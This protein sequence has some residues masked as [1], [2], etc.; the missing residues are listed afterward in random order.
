MRRLS[1]ALALIASASTAPAMSATP[2]LLAARKTIDSVIDRSKPELLALY[3]DLHMHPELSL[4]ET[5]TAARL[6]QEMR[7]LGLTVTEKVGGT[8]LVA[9]LKNGDGP[10]VLIRTDLDALPMRELSDAPFASKEEVPYRGAKT[11]VAHSCGHDLHMTWWLGTAKALLAVKDQW[12][13]TVVFVGQPA[14]EGGGGAQK[15][16]DDGLFTR[17]PKPDYGFA[18]HVGND[19][20]GKVTVK[21]GAFTSNSD[22]VRITFKGKGGHGSMPSETIDPIVMGARFV[23]DVQTVVSRQKDPFAFGVVTVGAFQAGT[24]PNIIPDS[25]ALALTIRSFSPSVREQLVSG[26]IRTAQTVATMS[27]APE[28]TVEHVKGASSVIN[29]SALAASVATSLKAA[30]SDSIALLP[31]SAPGSSASEDYSSLVSASGM[32]SVYLGIGGYLPSVLDDYRT[33]GAA[34]PTNH[35]PHFLPDAEATIPVGVRSFA[36]AALSVLAV[37]N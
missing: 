16:V 18:A 14:E 21:Q 31:E 35:S 3:R 2:D 1:F 9:I 4:Q 17:F 5:R 32:R 25:A 37:A 27:S 11:F 6:A 26:V 20:V 23:M 34:L 24:V 8:G 7:K 33:R 19:P 28:P 36:I 15:M 29:D 13:G 12:R 10:V 22:T 30:T